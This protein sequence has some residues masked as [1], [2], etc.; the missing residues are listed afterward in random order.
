MRTAS[1]Q[2]MDLTQGVIWKQLLR[3]FFPIWCG[4]FFQSLYSTADAIIIGQLVGT[5]A[6]AAVGNTSTIVNLYI[7]LFNGL[8]SGVTILVA[9]YVG[10]RDLTSANRCSHTA[11]SLGLFSGLALMV[12]SLLI[13]PWSLTAIDTPAD[14][15]EDSILYLRL[16]SLGMIPTAFYNIG[17]GV[18]RGMGDSR[19]PVYY[20]IASSVCNIVLDLLFVIAFRMGVAGVALATVISQVLSAVL[21]A[22]ALFRDET[23]HLRLRELVPNG[24]M[25][26][27]LMRIAVPAAVQSTSYGFTNILIQAGINSF[28]TFVVA[29]WTTYGKID[30]LYWMTL[31]AM[32]SALTTF[33]GQNYGARKLRRMK[34]GMRVAL[35][36]SALFTVALSTLMVLFTRP[37]Y[38]IFT[39]DPEVISIGVDM[40]RFLAPTYILFTVEELY[41][42]GIRAAG[43]AFWPMVLNLFSVCILRIAWVWFVL[44]LNHTI[45]ML[46]LCYPISWA[47]GSLLFLI[48]FRT[49]HWNRAGLTEEMDAA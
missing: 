7:G 9:Q 1:H 42:S 47:T 44:P 24:P 14:I 22:V 27:R 16:Y 35:G 23:V 6:L 5:N 19:R 10:G 34:K 43:D 28:G 49:G 32:S 20:L 18:L 8:A 11:L 21:V 29:A 40:V 17:S 36:L 30:L 38:L 33:V 45:F 37:L 12:L 26:Y 15:L 13:T 3:F 48:Y 2:E 25:T 4:I 39:S 31:N 41:A 46:C